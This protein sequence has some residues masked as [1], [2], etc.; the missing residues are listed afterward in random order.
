[1]LSK[2]LSI[3][4]MYL[5]GVGSSV[6]LSLLAYFIHG[7]NSS[8]K[9]KDDIIVEQKV[10]I[11][12]LE[13]NLSGYRFNNAVCKSTVTSMSL[14]VEQLKKQ[15]TLTDTYTIPKEVFDENNTNSF[16]ITF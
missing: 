1:M 16:Y 13:A 2:I 8:M 5:I 9:I 7:F 14:E 11:Q 10:Q 15:R 6:V 3:P 4:K 12:T